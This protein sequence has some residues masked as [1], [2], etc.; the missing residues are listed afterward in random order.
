MPTI[1]VSGATISYSDTGAPTDLPDAPTIVFGHGL[2][3]G[4]WMFRPQITALRDRYRC[5]AVDWRGQGAS[6][7]APGGYDMDTLT[8]DAVAL[9]QKL[10]VAPVHWVGLSMG[11][12]VGQRLAA[13]HGEL[14]RSLTLLDTSAGPEN[15]DRVGE[16]RLLSLAYRFLGIRPVKSKVAPL[17]FG[18][19]FL[20]DPG[21]EPVMDE[22]VRRLRRGDRA[23]IRRAVLAVADRVPVYQEIGGITVPTLVVVGADDLATPPADA[24][25]LA[26]GIPGAKLQIIPNCG[27][28]STLE[29]PAAITDLLAKFLDAADQA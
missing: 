27:H 2:L 21:S 19:G 20:A 6:P 11:G 22:W 14:L 8:N 3:F 7:A 24:E 1:D 13:R 16:F 26:A 15:P 10:D 5:V 17:L 25:R 29:Q 28:T 9:I 18:A 12:F 23:G 4:G